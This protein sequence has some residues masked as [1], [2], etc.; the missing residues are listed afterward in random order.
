MNHSFKNDGEAVLVV[1]LIVKILNNGID[2]NAVT[3]LTFYEAQRVEIMRV[4]E[5]NLGKNKVHAY[6]IFYNDNSVII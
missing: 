6:K 1:D 3:V 4:I 2:P 5:T